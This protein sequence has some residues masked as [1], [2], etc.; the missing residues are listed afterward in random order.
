LDEEAILKSLPKQNVVTAEE[1]NILEV[2]REYFK[3][4]GIKQPCPQEF[5]VVNDSFGESG[6]PA[7]GKIQIKQSSNCCSSRTSDQKK[8]IYLSV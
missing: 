8:I 2:L 7:H 6:T 4:V 5:A 1:H 3:S